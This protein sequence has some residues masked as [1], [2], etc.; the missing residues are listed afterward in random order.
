MRKKERFCADVRIPPVDECLVLMDLHGMMPNI[1]RH[2]LM[3]ARLAAILGRALNK[4]G[5]DLKISLI[6]AGA[7]LHDI[8]KTRSLRE[9]GNHVEMGRQMVIKMGYPEVA[10]IVGSHVDAGPEIADT[11]DE[12]TVVNY[13]DKR[14]QHDK[15]VPLEERFKDLLTRY[16]VSPDKRGRLQEMVRN[17][18]RL[19]ERIFSRIPLSPDCVEFM[20][21]TSSSISSPD[22]P[23]LEGSRGEGFGKDSD[24]SAPQK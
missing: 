7:L 10:R 22:D 18:E 12:A 21:E 9:G 4:G 13:A 3:V 24:E 20:I 5:T 23:I 1:R 8:A 15:V 16:G 6:V 17:V 14:V 19:E 11:I 2:S